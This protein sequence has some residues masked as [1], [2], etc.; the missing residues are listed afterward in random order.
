M[1]TSLDRLVSR[2]RVGVD[3]RRSSDLSTSILRSND[4]VL[5]AN[6]GYPQDAFNI[7]D[8]AFDVGSKISCRLNSPR[9]QRGPKGAR[10]SPGYS[11]NDVIQCG[12][13][14][15]PNEFTTILVFVE[16]GDSAVDPKMERFAKTLDRCGSVWPLMLFDQYSTCMNNR[17][18]RPPL[19]GIPGC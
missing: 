11:G 9:F 16:M 8:V 5:Q 2:T 12:W 3:F 15:R 14:L 18:F 4:P 19:Q 13:I 17:H 10:Q 7:L 6:P 1:D